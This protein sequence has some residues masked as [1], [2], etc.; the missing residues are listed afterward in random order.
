MV[1]NILLGG[2]L[3]QQPHSRAGFDERLIL[4]F[5][6]NC[7]KVVLVN[8]VFPILSD[9]FPVLHL[10]KFQCIGPLGFYRACD[11]YGIKRAH[12]YN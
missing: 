7:S 11:L 9:S 3:L 10:V 6:H 8:Q 2:H 12:L 4:E 5:K 1:T